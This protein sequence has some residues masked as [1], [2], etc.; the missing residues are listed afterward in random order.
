MNMNHIR[1]ETI[2]SRSAV[3]SLDVCRV[4][5]TLLFQPISY[6]LPAQSYIHAELQALLQ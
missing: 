6:N 3:V 1:L 2:Q 5:L 4:V